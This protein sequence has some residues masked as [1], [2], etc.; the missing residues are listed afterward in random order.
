MNTARAAGDVLS[1]SHFRQ[2]QQRLRIESWFV[3]YIH[4]DMRFLGL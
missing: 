4:E 3:P 1:L 2:R